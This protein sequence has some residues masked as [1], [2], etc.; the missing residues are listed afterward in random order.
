M[1]K[2]IAHIINSNIYSGL[3]NVVCTIM[4]KLSEDFDMIYVT[5]NGPIVS[6]L[7]E[8]EI[9]YFIIDRMNV[10]EIKRFIDQW[11][12]DILH[13]HDYT[14]S[15]V[16]AL[17]HSKIPVI[18]HLHNNSPWLKKLCIN[19][20]AYLYAGLSADK[21]LT[22]SHSIEQEYI[23][24]KFMKKKFNVIGNPIDREKIINQVNYIDDEKKYDICCVGRLTEQKDPIRFLKILKKIQNK[25]PK[26]KAIWIGDGELKDQVLNELNKLNLQSNIDFVGFQKNPYQYM[27]KSKIFILTSAWEGFGLAAFEAMTLGLPPIVSKVGGLIDIV[28]NECGFLCENNDN[29]INE[30]ERLLNSNEY[31]QNKSQKSLEKSKK[32]ENIDVYCREIIEIYNNLCEV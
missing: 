4:K 22:V 19:S 20:I 30:I 1:K 8:K 26:I 25:Y 2:K 11:E 10:K 27:K 16:C 21:I 24:S 5:K 18:N 7:K 15:V 9:P 29:F 6:T 28:D 14:A 12:P 32:L 31:L 13:A 17:H 23:F 3:E